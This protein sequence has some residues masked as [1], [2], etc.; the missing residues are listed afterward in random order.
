MTPA[1][2]ITPNLYSLQAARDI[3]ETLQVHS[4]NVVISRIG[5]RYVIYVDMQVDGK[6]II[7]CM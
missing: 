1:T 7:A 2:K 3:K 5:N 6:K 4:E